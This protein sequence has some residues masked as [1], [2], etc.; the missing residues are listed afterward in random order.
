MSGSGDLSR[1]A[2]PPDAELFS[3]CLSA[4]EILRTEEML[5][6]AL[7][8]AGGTP[9]LRL[10]RGISSI[11][12]RFRPVCDRFARDCGR[13]LGFDL[14]DEGSDLSWSGLELARL[15][16]ETDPRIHG[17]AMFLLSGRTA[18]LR[19]QEKSSA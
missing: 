11:E 3:L 1:R 10:H 9:D 4:E 2:D 6:V 19:S 15:L 7:G 17:S 18:L 8:L 12:D 16:R 13:A 14:P 5:R